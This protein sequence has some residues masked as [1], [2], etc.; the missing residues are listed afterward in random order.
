[1]VCLSSILVKNVLH[2]YM[3]VVNSHE[4]KEEKKKKKY[5]RI[6]IPA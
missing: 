1:M 2:A 3:F 4:Q 6:M 5:T